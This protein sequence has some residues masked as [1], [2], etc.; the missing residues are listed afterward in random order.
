MNIREAH[1]FTIQQL[2]TLV[3]LGYKITASSVKQLESIEHT[4]SDK[5]LNL[6]PEAWKRISIE[7]DDKGTEPIY[8][9]LRILKDRGINFD[10]GFGENQYDWELD[11][12]FNYDLR[13]PATEE[14][15]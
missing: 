12:S 9:V 4:K 8:I 2:M 14:S 7:I 15:K 3:E 6:P 13:D 1:D 11:W 10:T 5:G